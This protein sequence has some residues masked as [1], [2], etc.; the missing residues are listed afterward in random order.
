MI[1]FV[2]VYLQISYLRVDHNRE[3][4]RHMSWVCIW[5][6]KSHSWSHGTERVRSGG[7]LKRHPYPASYSYLSGEECGSLGWCTCCLTSVVRYTSHQIANGPSMPAPFQ[8]WN[9]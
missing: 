9:L 8:L 4:P 7:R 2:A 1:Y 6:K 5:G 3:R